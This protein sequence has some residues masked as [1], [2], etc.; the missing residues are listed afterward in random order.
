M[1]VERPRCGRRSPSSVSPGRRSSASG[2]RS[3]GPWRSRPSRP[4]SRA[5]P[6][7]ARRSP[8]T[9]RRSAARACPGPAST[10]RPI[11]RRSSRPALNRA[12]AASSAP[13][14]RK[15]KPRRR[16]PPRRQALASAAAASTVAPRRGVG[17][18]QGVHQ[19][20]PDRPPGCSQR[21]HEQCGAG[22]DRH[23]T[24]MARRGQH[25][26]AKTNV[27]RGEPVEV[28]EPITPRTLSTA[29][30]IKTN[31]I[32]RKLMRAGQFVTDQ[33]RPWTLRSGRDVG[34][35][36]T[37]WRL[38]DQGAGDSGRVADRAEFD[39][40][41]RST[42]PGSGS[43]ARAPVVTILGHVDH[44]KTSLLDKHSQRQRRPPV[45]AGGDHPGDTA[46][47]MVHA[48]Q[49]RRARVQAG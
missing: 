31:D 19:R 36:R 49:R 18:A 4:S 6:S 45:K 22:V 16:P 8:T 35:G 21:R 20:R 5:R 15:R 25:V 43:A 32:L 11:A 7:S 42:P 17:K 30:G 44:G 13:T 40:P 10:A 23:L 28:E 47:W 14:P 41:R 33:H 34:A 46:A 37:G 26:V 2:S 24:Q 29:L 3:P 1:P 38:T 48:V 27:Q 12:E 39:A 9:C